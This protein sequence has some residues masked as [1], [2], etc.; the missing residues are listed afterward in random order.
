[1][2]EPQECFVSLL[3]CDDVNHA[4]IE[5]TSSELA[6][7]LKVA[8]EVNSLSNYGCMPRLRVLAMHQVD[9]SDLTAYRDSVRER[10]SR[11]AG[12]E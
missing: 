4:V 8:D 10:D 7:L 12:D 5:L 11:A 2:S 3:G 9:D 6:T 1:M